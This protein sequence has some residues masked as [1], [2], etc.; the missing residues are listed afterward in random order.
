MRKVC[1]G[2]KI[3]SYLDYDMMNKPNIDGSEVYTL[4]SSRPLTKDK[5]ISKYPKVYG[6]RV[7]CLE[8]EYHIRLNADIDPVQCTPRRVP[9]ALRECLQYSLDDVVQQDILAPVTKPTPWVNLMV[10]VL[11]NYVLARR[12]ST[13]PYSMSTT[14]YLL[15][16]R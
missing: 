16:R 13:W 4:C 15:S 3:V 11:K 6:E 12:I 14:L 8:G 1:L 2:T 7:G 5:L 9:A 10:V